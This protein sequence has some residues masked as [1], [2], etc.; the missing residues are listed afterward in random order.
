MITSFISYPLVIL[1]MIRGKREEKNQTSIVIIFY[2]YHE[3]FPLSTNMT[4]NSRH[5]YL[6]HLPFLQ[7]WL[8][9]LY[10][11]TYLCILYIYLF[12]YITVIAVVLT[13]VIFNS[14][15]FLFENIKHR[16]SLNNFGYNNRTWKWNLV[17]S[18][19]R[20]FSLILTHTSRQQLMSSQKMLV[21]GFF[22]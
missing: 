2:E 5:E 19:S 20:N 6:I 8:R 11:Y 16:S 7:K 13:E 17:K 10:K 3:L 9:R 15:V 14:Y 22:N 1:N 12:T 21:L 18:K 4:V